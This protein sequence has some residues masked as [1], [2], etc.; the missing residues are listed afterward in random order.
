MGTWGH[1]ATHTTAHSSPGWSSLLQG[2]GMW[3]W[4]P[5]Q[6]WVTPSLLW[7]W[8]GKGLPAMPG[9]GWKKPRGGFPTSQPQLI[10]HVNFYQHNK[11]HPPQQ[12]TCSH[13]KVSQPAGVGWGPSVPLATHPTSPHFPV[14]HTLSQHNPSWAGLCTPILCFL[15]AHWSAGGL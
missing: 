11:P 4:A 3:P 6:P 5:R 12:S 15:P 14:V 7:A 8:R 1:G 2:P 10:S 13:P 9:R